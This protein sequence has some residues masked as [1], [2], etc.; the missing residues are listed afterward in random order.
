LEGEEE[1]EHYAC[2]YRL[3]AEDGSLLWYRGDPD[4]VVTADPG[5]VRAFGSVEDLL[6]YVRSH[7]ITIQDEE[8]AHFHLDL[9]ARWTAAPSSSTVDCSEFLNAWNLFGDVAASLGV[10][11][12]GDEGPL[13]QAVNYKL[14]LGCNLPSITPSGEHYVPEWTAEEVEALARVLRAGLRL[15]GSSVRRIWGAREGP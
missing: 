1:R 9:V 3:D 6:R 8:P 10:D 11:L 2:W 12:E 13:A 5:T 7:G 15:F 4:G 14:F